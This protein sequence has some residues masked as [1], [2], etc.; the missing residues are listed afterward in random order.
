MFNR[1]AVERK[2]IVCCGFSVLEQVSNPADKYIDKQAD[3]QTNKPSHITK[4][5][6][7]KQPPHLS[8]CMFVLF[9]DWIKE[10]LLLALLV[11]KATWGR[12]GKIEAPL[13]FVP[14]TARTTRFQQSYMIYALNNYQL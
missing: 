4:Y 7:H 5:T 10:K 3:R 14:Q 12:G 1:S 8:V 6:R 9:V 2:Y 11:A 13:P